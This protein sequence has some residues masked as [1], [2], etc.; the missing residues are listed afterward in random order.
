M[1]DLQ[2]PQI[3]N[4]EA[5]EEAAA[6]EMP[7]EKMRVST[8][9]IF[10]DWLAHSGHALA[11]STYQAGKLFLLGVKP[12]GK[13]G[14]TQRA[15]QRVMGLAAE[16]GDGRD[17]IYA[18]DL[19]QIWRFENLA[20]AADPDKGQDA[21]YIPQM[22]WVTGDIDVHDMVVDDEGLLFVNTLFSCLARPSDHASFKPVW[23]PPFISK[24]AAED[25]CHLNGLTL[26]EDGG[27][28]VTAISEADAADGWRSHRE[29]GGILMHADSN[30]ILINDLCMPHSPRFHKGALYVLD[31][32]KGDLLKIDP[33]SGDIEVVA[34]LPGY[35][36]GLAFIDNC[37]VIGLSLPRKDGNFGGLPLD[38][39]LARRKTEPR[40]GLAVSDKQTERR[41]DRHFR[42]HRGAGIIAITVSPV[43]R[44]GAVITIIAVAGRTG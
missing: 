5:P 15:L 25:R 24:L 44:T 26:A 9:R 7:P 39:A 40:C 16:Q 28:W 12:D 42:R 18:A 3:P 20:E 35:A 23:Q 43:G 32:G 11:F 6:A 17:S 2:E 10:P 36:R 14:I 30:E 38:E 31:S 22:S 4:P 37:A 27:K 29:A 8:S 13:L 41:C 34:F 21:C 1:S 19:Y 33:K